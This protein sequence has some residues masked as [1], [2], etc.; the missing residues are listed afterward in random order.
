MTK[1]MPTSAGKNIKLPL[2]HMYIFITTQYYT[3]KSTQVALQ[4]ST[5]SKENL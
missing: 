3:S 4:R 1:S 5:E 2:L